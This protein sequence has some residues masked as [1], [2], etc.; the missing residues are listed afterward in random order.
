MTHAQLQLKILLSLRKAC[1]IMEIGYVLS[2]TVGS[3]GLVLFFKE[4]A[5]SCGQGF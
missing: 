4:S 1:L 3:E 2:V 5:D